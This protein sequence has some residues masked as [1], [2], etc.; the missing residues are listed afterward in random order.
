MIIV[1]NMRLFNFI[2]KK[3]AII[4]L[5]LIGA[6][7]LKALQNKGFGLVAISSNY[8][9][10][11]KI[12]ECSFAQVVSSELEAARDSDVVFICTPIS[13]VK[14]ILFKLSNILTTKTLVTDV[15]SVKGFICEYAKGLNINFIGSHPMAGTENS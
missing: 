1:I 15:A 9:T 12:E 14:D 13:T 7:L 6:S 10:R 3:I 2:M 11:K 5:G 4:G 8:E